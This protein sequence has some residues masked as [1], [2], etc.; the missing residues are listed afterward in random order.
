MVRREDQVRGCGI[1]NLTLKLRWLSGMS[2]ITDVPLNFWA[3]KNI[4]GKIKFGLKL[5]DINDTIIKGYDDTK[6][7]KYGN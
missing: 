2:G 4:V 1:E 5:N 7:I 6:G 3:K